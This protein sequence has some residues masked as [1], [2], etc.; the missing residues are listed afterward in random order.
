MNTCENKS[1]FYHVKEF[2]KR[3]VRS[4]ISIIICTLY[5]FNKKKIIFENIL[6]YPAKYNFISYQLFYKIG[7]FFN[8]KIK[9][10]P[11]NIC[12]QN[13][14]LFGQ[15][16]IYLFISLI[17]GIILSFPFICYELWKFIKPGL[18]KKER[19]N[20]KK[21]FFIF[22]SLFII[23]LL[24]GYFIL[25]PFA[26]QFA[27]NFFISELPQNIFDLNDYVS[28][29]IESTLLMGIVFLFP[30]IPFFLKKI[31]II[32]SC[33]LKKYRKHAFL[34]LFII[35]S[36]ITTGDIITTII[37]FIPFYLLFEISLLIIN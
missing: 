6:F 14:Q 26:I 37:V 23:G 16:N 7:L 30:I 4:L 27:D 12:I 2:R 32:K 33:F 20:I 11:N 17:G 36:A 9:I 10:L 34:I 35:A 19:K 29:I 25:S 1:F 3:V 18:S 22:L 13:I 31:N 21:F 15:F 8:K 28:I 5:C 24:F